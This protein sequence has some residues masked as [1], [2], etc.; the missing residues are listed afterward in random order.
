MPSSHASAAAQERVNRIRAFREELAA[1]QHDG[2]LR[3]TDEQMGALDRHYG[4][5]FA[6]YTEQY[7]VDVTDA[8]RKLSLGMRIAAFVGAVALCAAVVLFVYRVWG[9]LDPIPQV[10]LLTAAPL[11]GLALTATAARLDG[12]K[13]FASMAALVA[14]GAFVA[15][16]QAMHDAFG[17]TPS[18]DRY[19]AWA[20]FGALLA[21]AFGLRLVFTAAALCLV[22]WVSA[23]LTRAAGGPL[24]DVAGAAEHVLAGGAVL[25]GVSAVPAQ[26]RLGCAGICRGLGAA[27]ALLALIVLGMEEGASRLPL[28]PAA[29]RTLYQLIGPL[30]AAGL[31]AAGIRRGWQETPSVATLGLALMVLLRFID[32]WW[33]RLP[34]Y[35]FFLLV[36]ALAVATLAVLRVVRRRAGARR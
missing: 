18:P 3:L 20:G 10:I 25:F 14:F 28:S 11:V 4:G 33:A 34:H 24:A 1:L 27:I 19:L 7:D 23:V 13:Y 31:I 29:A 8:A 26:G 15:D 32:W 35:L 30:V 9:L 12:T 16:L 17:L 36:G 22:A 5:L 6:S 21:Y 2:V